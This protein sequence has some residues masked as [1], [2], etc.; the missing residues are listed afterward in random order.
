MMKHL[1]I[2]AATQKLKRA[3]DYMTMTMRLTAV[4]CVQK[5]AVL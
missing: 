2:N 4:I 1:K 5:G 3:N